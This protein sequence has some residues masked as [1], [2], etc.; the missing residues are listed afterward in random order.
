[1]PLWLLDTCWD[2][3]MEQWSGSNFVT[4]EST[5]Y[6]EDVGSSGT[7]P[8]LPSSKPKYRTNDRQVDGIINMR[9]NFETRYDLQHILF[10]NNIRAFHNRSYRRTMGVEVIK[11]NQANLERGQ[12][13]MEHPKPKI[14][15]K[16]EMKKE[17]QRKILK[18]FPIVLT[19]F[20][21][22]TYT[23]GRWQSSSL[24]K[25]NMYVRKTRKSW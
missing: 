1:M 6:V 18:W 17:S 23:H 19:W 25:S 21:I 20:L 12:T 4:K 11:R 13:H 8:P 10:N 7:P 5:R 22:K 24:M 15:P 2:R 16:I 14:P 9:F 3:M